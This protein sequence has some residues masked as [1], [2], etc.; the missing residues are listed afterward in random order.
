MTKDKNQK[1]EMVE[2]F[3]KKYGSVI[4]TREQAAEALSISTSSLDRRK[5]MALPP[6]YIKTGPA[7]A[8][9]QYLVQDIVD[10]LLDSRVETL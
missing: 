3:L 6:K 8:K 4:L 9:V 7:N 2:L 10:F 1:N 5:S